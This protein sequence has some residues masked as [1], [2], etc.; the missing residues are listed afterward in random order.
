[1]RFWSALVPF[2]L[3]PIVAANFHLTLN[4]CKWGGYGLGAPFWG[5]TPAN[6]TSCQTAV[7][8]YFEHPIKYGPEPSAAVCGSNITIFSE[9]REWADL[10]GESGQCFQINDGNGHYASCSTHGYY[11]LSLDVLWCLSD[12]CKGPGDP[13][14]E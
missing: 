13:G 5:I 14:M 11:C 8:L 7:D 4:F 9:D 1:M 6:T 3:L 10:N 2:A 12:W